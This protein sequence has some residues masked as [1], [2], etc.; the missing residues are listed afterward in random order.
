MDKD[1]RGCCPGKI[2]QWCAF[3]FINPNL[4]SRTCMKCFLCISK[5]QY[6]I[7]YLLTL[8]VE[9]NGLKFKNFSFIFPSWTL[10]WLFSGLLALIFQSGVILDFHQSDKCTYTP[11]SGF[12]S[13][14]I[15]FIWGP[16]AIAVKFG[17]ILEI[18]LLW[19]ETFLALHQRTTETTMSS[20]TFLSQLDWTFVA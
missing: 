12:T 8:G 10:V 7:K 11:N 3:W 13:E 1:I 5:H 20:H 19:T 2:T 14:I 9:L 6:L 16:F 4:E 17:Q 18:G 15:C